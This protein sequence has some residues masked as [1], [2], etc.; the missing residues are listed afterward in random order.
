MNKK[1]FLLFG[2]AFT[3]TL[4][5]AEPANL[6][7]GL[8]YFTDSSFWFDIPSSWHPDHAKGKEIGVPLVLYPKGTTWDN[9]PSVMYINSNNKHDGATFDQIVSNDIKSFQSGS[10]KFKVRNST[11]VKTKDGKKTII[12]EMETGRPQQPYESIAYIDEKKSVSMMVISSK[13]LAD[14]EKNRPIFKKMVESYS[15]ITDQVKIKP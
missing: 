15:F 1:N 13:T 3:S 9:A 8:A 10:T 7:S 14:L 11:P 2:I 4:S 6:N 5:L 12:K